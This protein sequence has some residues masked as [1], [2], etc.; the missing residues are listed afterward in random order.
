MNSEKQTTKHD[1]KK[2]K[3]QTKKSEV[4]V[5]SGTPINDSILKIFSPFSIAINLIKLSVGYI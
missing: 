5:L 3:R 2:P 1:L 4:N